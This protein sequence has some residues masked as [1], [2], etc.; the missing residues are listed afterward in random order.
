MTIF[1]P[2]NLLWLLLLVPVIIFFYLL[3]LKR[4]EMVVSSVLLWSRLVKDV[5]AN[6]PFQKLKKNLLL[7]LQLLIAILAILALARP[8][9]FTRSLGGSNV[10]VVLDGSAS[11]QSRDA[12]GTRFA[13][14]QAAALKMVGDMHGGDRMMVLLSGART[15]RLTG[16]TSD[17]NELR[18][19]ISSAAPLD[20]TTNLREALLLAVS[21]AGSGILSG[22]SRIYVLSD[23]AFGDL[24][25]LDTR[26]SEVQFVKIGSRSDNVGV[27]AMDVRRSFKDEGGYQMFVAVRN[28]SP[29]AKKCNLEFYRNEALIDVRPVELPPADKALGFSEKAEV[30]NNIVE[31]TGILRARLDLNDDLEADNEAYSQLSPRREVNVLLVTDGNLYLEKALNLDPHVKLSTSTPSA[32]NGQTGFD[33]VVFENSGPAEVGP[34][35]HLYIN[36]GGPTAP[37][38]IKGKITNATI[39]DWERA[40]PAMRYVKLSQ[41]QMSEALTATRRPWGVTL[42]EHEQGP[43]LVVGEKGGVKSAYV[44]FPL[45]KTEFPLRVA[46]PIFFN[47][48]V[49]W[50]ATR[51]GQTEGLQLRTG[52]TAPVEVPPTVTELTVTDPEGRKHRVRPEGRLAYISDTERRGIYTVEGKDFKQEFAVNL[53]SRDESATQPQDR[54]RFG[55]RSLAAAD[56]GGVRTA[57]EVWRWLALAALLILGLEWWVFHK[58]I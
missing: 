16:F 52:E 1:A 17:K 40:H 55:R 41:L 35:A 44:G 28:F 56:A 5:Q 3:K 10:V 38:D 22:G 25:E 15:H 26:G 47:N 24:D 36:C 34:G 51:P 42:A 31:A 53:L 32:Y 29:E 21:A 11:M 46:F 23:G 43:A 50:L 4:R 6:A 27:V 49:Q 7:L 9:F 18:R 57:R 20:T 45:L 48:M 58:R 33:V 39:L 2:L 12:G 8:A 30:F 14:A 37:V 13:A 54:I 19:A